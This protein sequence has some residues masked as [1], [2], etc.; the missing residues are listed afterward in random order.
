MRISVV[1]LEVPEGGLEGVK[2]VPSATK[3]RG[4]VVSLSVPFILSMTL[5]KALK[6][7]TP[8][9]PANFLFYID[10]SYGPGSSHLAVHRYSYKYLH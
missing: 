4:V 2:I 10:S 7:V 1:R 5:K 6:T 3:N 9:Q 8:A